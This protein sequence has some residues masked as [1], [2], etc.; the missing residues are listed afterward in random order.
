[1]QSISSSTMNATDV[2]HREIK[3]IASFQLWAFICE[4]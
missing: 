4:K 2:L 3:A 1:M